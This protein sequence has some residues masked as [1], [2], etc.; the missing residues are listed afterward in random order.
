M[1]GEGVPR[2]YQK[3]L[4]WIRKAARQGYRKAQLNLG[5][6]Y[7]NGHG[8]EKNYLFAYVLFNQVAVTLDS[9]R[10]LLDRLEARMM[11]WEI[12]KAQA[13]TIDDVLK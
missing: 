5:L 11:P 3:A 7:V 4:Q 13:M 8:I 6:M 9:A 1:T 2:D 10:E 12:V